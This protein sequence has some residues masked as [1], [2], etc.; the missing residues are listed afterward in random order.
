MPRS[1]ATILA[2]AG[3]SLAGIG[4]AAYSGQWSGTHQAIH[5]NQATSEATV[6]RRASN[7][8][9]SRA[10]AR[11]EASASSRAS[12][13]ASASSTASSDGQVECASEATV[14][15]ESNGERIT[16]RQARRFTGE[17]GGCNSTAR[18]TSGDVPPNSEAE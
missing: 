18:A 12:S 7:P 1:T 6:N 13:S 9:P 5:A 10:S 17:R 3:L 11:A 2:I 4:A 16:V 14:T 15:S 8:A